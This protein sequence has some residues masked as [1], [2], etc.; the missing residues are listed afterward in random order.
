VLSPSHGADS[1]DLRIYNWEHYLDPAVAAEFRRRY[2]V[3]IRQTFFYSDWERDLRVASGSSTEFDLI[4]LDAA[5]VGPYRARGWIAPIGVERVPALAQYEARWRQPDGTATHALPYAWGTL[6]IAYRADLVTERPDSWS[7]LFRPAASL[8]GRV[9]MGDDARELVAIALKAAGHSANSV[10]VA[11]Y[12]DA[13]QMLESQRHCVSGY[14][15]PGTSADSPLLAGN[16]WV[17]M[18]YSTDAAW[19]HALNQNVRFV[20]P[21]GGGL[22]WADYLVVMAHS[23]HKEL[24]FNFL[25]FLSEPA[26]AARQATYMRAGTPNGRARPLLQG[27]GADGEMTAAASDGF[28]SSELIGAAPPAVISLRNQIFARLTRAD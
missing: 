12:R 27:P 20:I 21:R 23:H 6:G 3:S 9:L 11:D 24:A 2:G 4:V 22:V 10:N 28:R 25:R 5:Q 1:P 8:C 15:Y 19:L 26:V 13:E 14:K 17:A 7:A 16:A 18:A